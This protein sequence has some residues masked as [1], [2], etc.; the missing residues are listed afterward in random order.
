MNLHRRRLRVCVCV[1][2]CGQVGAPLSP[3]SL[4]APVCPSK[5]VF[6]GTGCVEGDVAGGWCSNLS[7]IPASRNGHSPIPEP[8][9]YVTFRGKKDP[10]WQDEP[11]GTRV[12]TGGG[13]EGPGQTPCSRPSGWRKGPGGEGCGRHLEA[14]KGKETGSPPPPEPPS[15]LTPELPQET[16]LKRV[17]SQTIRKHACVV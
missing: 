9:E 15:L 5:Q 13:R 3:S 12:L 7:G 6:T 16:R 1:C 14:A 2:L 4:Q 8:S 10:R 11:V 17:I